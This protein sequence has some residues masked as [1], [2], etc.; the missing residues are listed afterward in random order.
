MKITVVYEEEDTQCEACLDIIPA[1][2]RHILIDHEPIKG[3]QAKDRLCCLC[4]A[5][6][7]IEVF[8]Q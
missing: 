4:Y 1:P 6:P 7:I 3:I 5:K 2:H 8:T